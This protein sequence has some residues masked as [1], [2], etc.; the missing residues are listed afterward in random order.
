MRSIPVDT[1]TIRFIHLGEIEAATTNEGE[2]RLDTNGVAMWK[3]PVSSI[4]LGDKKPEGLVVTVASATKPKFEQGAELH[5]TGL[6]ARSWQ[7]G[8]NAGTSF[9]AEKVEVVR[10][11]V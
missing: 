3:V 5:F 6:R 7:M 8:G 2:P 11:K 1:S 10:P 9:T 4:V